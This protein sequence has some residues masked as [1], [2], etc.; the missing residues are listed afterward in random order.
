MKQYFESK[1]WYQPLYDKDMFEA[2]GGDSL[3]NPEEIANRDLI[4]MIENERMRKT[5]IIRAV[6]C[7][8]GKNTSG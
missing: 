2:Q 3:L 5:S 7:F 4:Q 1:S 8:K 6:M